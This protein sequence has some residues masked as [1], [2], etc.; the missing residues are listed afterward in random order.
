MANRRL[1]DPA[2]LLWSDPGPTYEGEAADEVSI[3]QLLTATS[4]I[5]DFGRGGDEPYAA[6]HTSDQLLRMFSSGPLKHAPGTVFN[7]NNAD[8]VILGKIIESV[9]GKGYGRPSTSHSRGHRGKPG[10]TR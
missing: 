6:R 8:Y 5:E 3:R 9:S 1:C 2:P 7:D 4:G 10:D